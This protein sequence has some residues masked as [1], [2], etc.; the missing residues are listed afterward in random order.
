MIASGDDHTGV[1]VQDVAVQDRRTID[2]CGHLRI[3]D[4]RI[5]FPSGPWI[6]N[7]GSDG[8]DTFLGLIVV[9]DPYFVC[10]RGIGQLDLLRILSVHRRNTAGGGGENWIFMFFL[11]A[12]AGRTGQ[13]NHQFY[14]VSTHVCDPSIPKME[15]P[16]GDRK[17]IVEV[18]GRS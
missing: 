3:K 17:T 9:T 2:G 11:Y 15:A 14:G 1:T 6:G 13:Q 8:F 10:G 16:N 12:V 7:Y 18:N 5:I 4:R